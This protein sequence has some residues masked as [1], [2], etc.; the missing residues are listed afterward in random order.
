[1]CTI[2][3]LKRYCR[4]SYN[5]PLALYETLKR[6]G[7]HIVTVTDHDS[8]GA[9]EVLRRFPDFF[10]SEEVTCILPGGT[11]AHIAVYDITERQH[12]EIQARRNDVLRLIAYLREQGLLFGVNH[13]FSALTGRRRAMDFAL[14]EA[15]FPMLETRNGHIPARSNRTAER[16]AERWGKIATGGSDSHTM[17]PLARTWTEVPG[18]STVREFI[19]GLRAGR[20]TVAGADGTA[21]ILTPD[22]ARNRRLLRP[23]TGLAGVSVSAVRRGSGVHRN[24]T[25]LGHPVCL[26]MGQTF[27][28]SCTDA[29]ARA[30]IRRGLS[31]HAD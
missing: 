21:W 4:E 31:A 30:A 28:T 18:A 22:G 23:R 12:V 19:E 25:F 10:V 24:R 6:R 15:E 8:V 11:E 1:M 3:V 2:P 17:G 26:D 14:F 16:T 9:A 27:S 13:A 7:M 5:D 29:R 20:A